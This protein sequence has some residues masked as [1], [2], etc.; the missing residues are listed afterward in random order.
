MRRR[1]RAAAAHDRSGP[2]G[3]DDAVGAHH[4]VTAKHYTQMETAELDS[5]VFRNELEARNPAQELPA[6]ALRHK[7]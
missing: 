1:R 6:E 4:N 2:P 3:Y 7:E 5:T